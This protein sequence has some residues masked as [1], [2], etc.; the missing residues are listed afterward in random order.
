M[1]ASVQR[2]MEGSVP[3]RMRSPLSNDAEEY[4]R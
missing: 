1:H 3:S 2:P 4:S